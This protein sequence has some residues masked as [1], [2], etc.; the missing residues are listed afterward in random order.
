MV[1][2]EVML[3]VMVFFLM[4]RRPPR[5]TLFPYTTLFRSSVT[6][7]V[8]LVVFGSNWS[9]CVTVAVFL[10]AV[11]AVTGA[12]MGSVSGTPRAREHTCQTPTHFNPGLSPPL[13][14]NKHTRNRS[15]NVPR[16]P[17][18]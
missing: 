15:A 1:S 16:R 3:W 8:L 13:S 14:K 5:S 17:A 2:T 12:V 4:I 9:E 7:A 11:E 10:V 6:L 18:H